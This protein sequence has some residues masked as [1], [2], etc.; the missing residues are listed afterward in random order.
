M[1]NIV[2]QKSFECTWEITK[3]PFNTLGWHG[4]SSLAS[5]TLSNRLLAQTLVSDCEVP[6]LGFDAVYALSE[7]DIAFV[8]QCEECLFEPHPAGDAFVESS[9]ISDWDLPKTVGSKTPILR[10]PSSL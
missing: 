9:R 1:P 3:I 2:H 6:C 4:I 8:V 5:D 10:A 7:L